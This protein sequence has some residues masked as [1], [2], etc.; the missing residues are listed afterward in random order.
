MKLTTREHKRIRWFARVVTSA[1]FDEHNFFVENFA[2]LAFEGD[3]FDGESFV[4]F[5]IMVD[6]G[7]HIW[8]TL[9]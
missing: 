8:A 1:P 5:V 6:Q 9:S 4:L 7:S 2:V 3:S